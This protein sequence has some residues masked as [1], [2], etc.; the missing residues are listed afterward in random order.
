[1][2]REEGQGRTRDS[3]PLWDLTG[4]SA[5]LSLTLLLTVQ[6]I[7]L[8]SSS[9]VIRLFVYLPFHWLSY[10]CNSEFLNISVFETQRYTLCNSN[11]LTCKNPKP[12]LC[13]SAVLPLRSKLLLTESWGKVRG[14]RKGKEETSII[15]LYST[16]SQVI[17]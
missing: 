2:P 11:T 14:I 5:L 9:R 17:F 1:M 12:F 15:I 8:F 7:F 4:I 6:K 10:R 13:F 3:P 16:S